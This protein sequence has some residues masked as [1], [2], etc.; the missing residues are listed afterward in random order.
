MHIVFVRDF[1]GFGQRYKKFTASA[2]GCLSATGVLDKDVTHANGGNPEEVRTVLPIDLFGV[3][4]PQVG[5]MHQG[6]RLQRVTWPLLSEIM[7]SQPSQLGVN[8]WQQL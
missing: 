2:F 8:Q 7:V 1:L 6:R 4:Q 3:Q 5:F